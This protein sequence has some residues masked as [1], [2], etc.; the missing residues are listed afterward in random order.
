M[1]RPIIFDCT[2]REVGYQTGW[3]FDADYIKDFFKFAMTR[4]IDYVELGFFHNINHDQNRGDFRYCSTRNEEIKEIFKAIKNR[5]K[6]TAM[7]DIQRPLSELIPRKDSAIDAIRILTRS[8]ETDLKLLSD[9]IDEVR[10]L[11]Y[12]V[13][14]NF[15]SAGYNDLDTNK[16]FIE[17]LAEKGV[18]TVYFA[19]TESVM[20]S[21]YVIN[22]IK[23]CQERGLKVGMHFH[24]KNGTAELLADLAITH[25]VDSIDGTLIGLGGKMRDGNLSLEYI[26]RKFGLNP[27]YELTN[28]KNG[29]I[30]QL[31]KYRDFTAAG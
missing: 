13:F 3:Y 14:V 28:L 7:R 19:D 4:S 17:F 10:D 26:L 25:G 12:E 8:H 21:D 24:D 11:G 9:H 18:V 6:L 2:F 15:T 27:G 23:I 30:E 22:T 16:K 5:T 31:I 20:T 29:L 1:K